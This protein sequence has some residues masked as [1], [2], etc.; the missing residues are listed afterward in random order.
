MMKSANGFLYANRAFERIFKLDV[1]AG[2]VLKRVRWGMPSEAQD[3]VL[4]WGCKPSAERAQ[5]WATALGLPLVRMEDGFLR[6]FG[7]GDKFS[8]LSLVFDPEGIYYNCFRASS[9]E[10]LLNSNVNVLDA[11]A[12]IAASARAVLL[13]Q[14][15][16]KYNHAPAW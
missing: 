13:Q 10:T 2:G 3:A 4:G 1:L 7:T 14:R 12:A 8:P 6:S 5:K 16:S 15:L 11:D 9:L